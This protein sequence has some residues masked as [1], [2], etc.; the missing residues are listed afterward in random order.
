M[1]AKGLAVCAQI[2]NVAWDCKA[3]AH[4]VVEMPSWARATAQCSLQSRLL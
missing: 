4:A 3:T 1:W 2:S